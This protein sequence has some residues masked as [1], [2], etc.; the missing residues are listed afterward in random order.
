MLNNAKRNKISEML[1]AESSDNSI[2]NSLRVHCATV[3]GVKKMMKEGKS[4]KCAK[5]TRR[6]CASRMEDVAKAITS[7]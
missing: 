4:I 3:F 5:P 7:R 1:R 6:K 2:V